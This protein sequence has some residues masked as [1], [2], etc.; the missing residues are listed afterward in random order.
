MR[1]ASRME[2]IGGRRNAYVRRALPSDAPV[3][4]LADILGRSRPA[5]TR[6]RSSPPGAEETALSLNPVLACL[7]DPAPGDGMTARIDVMV[8]RRFDR[9]RDGTAILTA[10]VSFAGQES[11]A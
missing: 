2:E 7:S 5:T 8:F 1:V 6:L 11:S 3:K 4:R 9:A 10:H